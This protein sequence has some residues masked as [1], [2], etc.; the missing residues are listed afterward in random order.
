MVDLI[1]FKYQKLHQL[2][3]KIFGSL[4]K[5]E[6]QNKKLTGATHLFISATIVIFFFNRES[7]IP[8]LIILSLADALAAIFGSIFGTH[9]LF[10]K[11]WEGSLVF[12]F[13][14]FIIIIVFTDLTTEVVFLISGLLT[15]IE[16]LPLPFNDN[17]SVAIGG[18]LILS[19]LV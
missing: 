7:V 1:R 4:L 10:K 6:E 16:V 12:F 18:A 5:E 3:L 9:R 14:S 8:A 17:Y 19:F 15:T 11:T 2:F 13:V